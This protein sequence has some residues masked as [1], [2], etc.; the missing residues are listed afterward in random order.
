MSRGGGLRPLF[1]P[2]STVTR[3][4]R[5]LSVERKAGLQ[6]YKI[7]CFVYYE[8]RDGG[9]SPSAL[10]P[11]PQQPPSFRPLPQGLGSIQ[12]DAQSQDAQGRLTAGQSSREA[13]TV[14]GWSSRPGRWA[15]S[16]SLLEASGA[17][18][19]P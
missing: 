18:M 9:P 5:H 19:R 13:A 1:Q 12:D 15:G 10:F 2:F 8:I 7:K 14:G 17:R 3:S 6:L 11:L 16:L 4:E